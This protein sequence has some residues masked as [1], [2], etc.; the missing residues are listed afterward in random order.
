MEINEMKILREQLLPL[1]TDSGYQYLLDKYRAKLKEVEKKILEY[2]D[3][4]MHSFDRLQGQRMVLVWVLFL[5]QS[6]LASIDES[7]LRDKARKKEEDDED[8]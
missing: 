2:T 7:L 5:L 1:L 4:D 3:K 8:Y 6:E